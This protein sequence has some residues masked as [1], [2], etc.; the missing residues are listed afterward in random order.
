ML[1]LAGIPTYKSYFKAIMDKRMSY[2]ISF[3][4]NNDRDIVR[5]YF[6]KYSNNND[7]SVCLFP[8]K[9]VDDID[10]LNA[11]I[12]TDIALIH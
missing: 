9:I 2:I 3:C 12:G 8:Q 10:Y 5:K 6:G 4:Q 1:L 11:F 7:I